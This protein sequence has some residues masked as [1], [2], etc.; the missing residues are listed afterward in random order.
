MKALAL[1]LV[2][3]LG[4][5][6]GGGSDGND[7]NDGNDD[8]TTCGIVCP[9]EISITLVTRGDVA[10]DVHA[11]IDAQTSGC[12]GEG[13]ETSRHHRPGQLR[14]RHRDRLRGRPGLELRDPH[15]GR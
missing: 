4:V 13:L 7:G 5:A 8:D 11:A 12:K 10:T 1:G 15:R 14:R 3:M 2:A 9:A 6:C